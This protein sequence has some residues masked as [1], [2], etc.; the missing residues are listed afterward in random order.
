MARAPARSSARS[1]F[2]GRVPPVILVFIVTTAV[3]S[4]VGAVGIRHGFPLVRWCTLSPEAVLHGQLWRLFTWIFF[5]LDPISLLFACLMLYWFGRDLAYRW[6]AGRFVLYYMGLTT[7]VGVIIVGLS[8]LYAPLGAYQ[9]TGSWPMQEALII[10]WATYYPTRQ[11]FVYFVLP[12]GGRTLILATIAGTVLFSLFAG[13]EAFIPH[14]LAEGIALAVL[15]LPS[16]SALWFERKLHN[17]EKQR[18]ASHLKIV[19]RDTDL[20]DHDKDGPPGKDHP[21]GGRW[22]N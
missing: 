11:I 16:P 10:F 21:P 5:E 6:G 18:R 17:L 12:L 7:A 13:L 15:A 9:W 8:R 3:A 2:G 20:R 4:I 1:L 22:L 19:P 14:F